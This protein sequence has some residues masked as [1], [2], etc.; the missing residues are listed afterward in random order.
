[1]LFRASRLTTLPHA[2]FRAALLLLFSFFSLSPFCFL[3]PRAAA[4]ITRQVLLLCDAG[5]CSEYFQLLLV[6]AN[7]THIHTL[8]NYITYVQHV[9]Y[10]TVRVYSQQRRYTHIFD[11][12]PSF[13]LYFWC[14]CIPISIL[15]EVR[16]QRDRS[17]AQCLQTL[18][19]PPREVMAW[20][21]AM[22][23]AIVR[24]DQHTRRNAA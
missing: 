24:D 1:M 2:C 3:P 18:F 17:R 20:A 7:I 19:A 11:S 23:S 12:S 15:V 4:R 22:I 5:C 9:E 13:T 8:V 6:Y 21:A 14:L 10:T 16:S